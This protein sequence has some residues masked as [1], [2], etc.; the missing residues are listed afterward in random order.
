MQQEREYFNKY[1][2]TISKER[3]LSFSKNKDFFDEKYILTLYKCNIQISQAFYPILSHI[4]IV[5][6]NSIDTMLQKVISKTWLEEELEQ[7]NLLFDYDYEKLSNANKTIKTRYKTV[8]RGKIISEL[9]FGFWV[10][11]CTKK[12]NPKIW[13]KKGA[14]KGVF[15]N[16][17]TNLKEEIHLI[18]S[19]LAKIKSLRNRIFHYEPILNKNKQYVLV[20]GDMLEIL[21]Y[22]PNDNSDI[23]YATDNF[24]EIIEKT[25]ITL[26]SLLHEMQ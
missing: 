21:S 7:Q 17:P 9:T 1:K 26:D 5:L 22:L 25:I 15:I 2:A 24:K 3:L 8:T 16:Y 12:Y 19:K 11:L 4:E 18:S 13:T 20:Y 10:N 6:R 23:L 14:F